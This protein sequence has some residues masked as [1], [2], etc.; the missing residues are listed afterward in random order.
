[1]GWALRYLWV[2]GIHPTYALVVLEAVVS[3]GIWT[4]AM[5]PEDL[6]SGLGMLL[7]VQMFL[8]SSGFAIRARRGHFDQLLMRVRARWH[9]ALLHGMVSI[10]PGLAAW[11]LLTA[12]GFV[13]RSPAAWSAFAGGRMAALLIV[14]SLAWAAGFMLPRGAAAVAW[15]AVLIGLLVERID[16]LAAPWT[17][18]A[19]VFTLLRH[20]L[21][22][23]VCPFLLLGSH[24][25]VAPGSEWGA[26]CLAA[27]SILLVLRR[28]RSLDIYLVDRT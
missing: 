9:V 25:P 13:F 19:G 14:S 26:L 11:A 22:L 8:A 27:A 28:S 4:V 15:L 6:D 24:P 18:P 3:I 21:T 7:F 1:M 2:V 12:A 20:I 23:L 17:A 16:L 5:N 10:G